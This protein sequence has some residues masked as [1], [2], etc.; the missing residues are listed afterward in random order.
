MEEWGP[1][2]WPGDIHSLKW[3]RTGPEL[4]EPNVNFWGGYSEAGLG[5]NGMGGKK[6]QWQIQADESRSSKRPVSGPMRRQTRLH[7]AGTARRRRGPGISSVCWR[8]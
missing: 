1:G 7:A 2:R 4:P 5:R 3:Q 6:L 8:S